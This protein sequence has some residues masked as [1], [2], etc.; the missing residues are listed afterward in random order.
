MRPSKKQSEV[1][2][3]VRN[4]IDKHGYGPSYRDVMRGMGYASVSTVASHIEALI[5]KGQLKKTDRYRSLDTVGPTQVHRFAEF[6]KSHPDLDVDQALH[7]FFG[8]EDV[9]SEK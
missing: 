3:F 1:L 4:F 8:A 7:L 6:M 2:A 5:A 9:L